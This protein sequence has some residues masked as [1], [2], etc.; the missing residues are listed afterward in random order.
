MAQNEVMKS[1]VMD[2]DEIER[3]VTRIAHQ[4]LERN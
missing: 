3:A 4:I 1:S 2:A